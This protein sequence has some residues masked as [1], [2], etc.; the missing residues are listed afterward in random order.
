MFLGE[1]QHTSPFHEK[2]KLAVLAHPLSKCPTIVV[3]FFAEKKFREHAR[4]GWSC[5]RYCMEGTECACLGAIPCLDLPLKFVRSEKHVIACKHAR[6]EFWLGLA[7]K[8]VQKVTGGG[9][10][11]LTF[12]CKT[13]RG[14]HGAHVHMVHETALKKGQ[15]NRN[16]FLSSTQIVSCRYHGIFFIIRSDIT[17]F[18]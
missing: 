2:K 7:R 12:R 9:N 8:D 3:L 14:E 16:R 18:L 4:S 5:L 13:I 1:P 15:S 17:P 10:V 11:T 6:F